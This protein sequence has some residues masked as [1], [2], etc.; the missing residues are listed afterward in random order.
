MNQ[1]PGDVF[2]SYISCSRAQNSP[3][4]FT[5]APQLPHLDTCV[6]EK[7]INLEVLVE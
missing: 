7:L 1:Y 3:I 2:A 5:P 4:V 6:I